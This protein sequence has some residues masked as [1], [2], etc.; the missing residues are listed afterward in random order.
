MRRRGPARVSY[1]QRPNLL[2]NGVLNTGHRVVTV[3]EF[4]E[5]VGGTVG[6]HQLVG[7]DVV[8]FGRCPIDGALPACVPVALQLSSRGGI[9][10]TARSGLVATGSRAVTGFSRGTG[11][12]LAVIGSVGAFTT[13][14]TV[15]ALTILTA[16]GSIAISAG[17]SVRTVAAVGT[18]GAVSAFTR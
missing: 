3:G 7:R 5:P 8:R 16:V 10:C 15:G 13:T 1:P 6:L 9:A 12:T 4:T 11:G 2:P 17:V 18:R 14:G